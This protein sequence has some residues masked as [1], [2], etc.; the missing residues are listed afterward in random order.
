MNR[1]WSSVVLK[2]HCRKC[3]MSSVENSN[4]WEQV[5]A[6]T[7]L[8]WNT[9]RNAPRWNTNLGWKK[10]ETIEFGDELGISKVQNPL[11]FRNWYPGLSRI[12]PNIQVSLERCMTFIN[13]FYVDS[14]CKTCWF[15]PVWYKT[16]VFKG[17]STLPPTTFSRTVHFHS[18]KSV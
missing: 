18:K 15:Q 1:G 12:E 8:A 13:R 16:R 9:L 11:T 6:L 7:N 17:S 14:R 3:N 5:Q 2:F 4:L 10:D